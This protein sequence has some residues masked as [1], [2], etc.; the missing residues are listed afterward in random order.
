[1][2]NKQSGRQAS[3]P[4]AAPPR[5]VPS[6]VEPIPGPDKPPRPYDRQRLRRL[7]NLS[8]ETDLDALCESAA[9][10]IESLRDRPSPRPWRNDT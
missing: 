1:M 5:S 9:A 4:D 7:L 6:A 3:R 10:E 8:P 2:A